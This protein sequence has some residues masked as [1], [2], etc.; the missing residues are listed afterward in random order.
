MVRSDTAVGT[1]DY[2]SPEVLKSQAGDGYYGRECDW[3]SVGVFLYEMLVGKSA[4]KVHWVKNVGKLRAKKSLKRFGI[5]FQIQKQ[6]CITILSV[7][8]YG[9]V[10]KLAIALSDCS[11]LL[12][13]VPAVKVA[14]AYAFYHCLGS[15]SHWSKRGQPKYWLPS[16]HI[17]II[18]TSM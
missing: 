16:Y 8:Y 6:A 2:I 18:V 15:C 14:P 12:R 11:V 4:T 13:A 5:I 3:W 10:I 9:I 17:N 7:N 1:P